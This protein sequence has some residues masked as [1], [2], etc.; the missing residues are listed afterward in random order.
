MGFHGTSHVI[1]MSNMKLLGSIWNISTLYLFVCI[2]H[3]FMFYHQDSRYTTWSS[4]ITHCVSKYHSKSLFDVH[5]N[6]FWSKSYTEL[7]SEFHGTF[8]PTFEQ[9]LWFH[10]IAWNLSNISSS[11]M[12]F[13]GILSRSKVPWN[14]MELFQYSWV[15]ELLSPHIHHFVACKLYILCWTM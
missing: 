4:G 6:L 8:R 12:D 15:P 9:H 5:W 10:G 13:H 11:S 7:S 14:S 2:F 3:P 1:K